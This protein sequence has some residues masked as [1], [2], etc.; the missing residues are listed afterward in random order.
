MKD[1]DL[2]PSK[3]LVLVKGF[4]IGFGG[5]F[6]PSVFR[7]FFCGAFDSNLS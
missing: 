5:K 7:K 2:G 3:N 1:P 4:K 6:V